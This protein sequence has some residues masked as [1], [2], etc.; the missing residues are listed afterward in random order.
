MK[1]ESPLSR[2]EETEKLIDAGAGEL[3]CGV[4]TKSWKKK[5]TILGCNNRNE[6]TLGNLNNLNELKQVVEIAK[7]YDVPVMLT[8]NGLYT[9]K[10][11]PSLIEFTERA[12]DTGI[13]DIIVADLSYLLTLSKMNTGVRIHISTGGTAFNSEAVDFY[14]HLGASRVILPRH[15]TVREIGKIAEKSRRIELATF[16]FYGIDANIDGFCTFH[17]GLGEY[18]RKNF[19]LSL[20]VRNNPFMMRLVQCVPERLANLVKQTG[21]MGCLPACWL[22][23]DVKIK[24]KSKDLKVKTA[25]ERISNSYS[26]KYMVQVACGICALYDFN[27]F[28]ITSIKIVGRDNATHDK[29]KYVQFLKKALDLL[30]KNKSREEFVESCQELY[31]ATFNSKCLIPRCY[32]PFALL[33]SN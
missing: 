5:Y 12:L 9:K 27:K 15:L 7:S 22:S 2:V 8:I 33:R 26:F 31:K 17:H 11:Y 29:V 20:F 10:Q 3:Y 30:N 1:I 21:Y 24:P 13:K 14:R 23:Y 16:I 6:H 18:R 4:C 19:D 32:Y 25:R 28:N